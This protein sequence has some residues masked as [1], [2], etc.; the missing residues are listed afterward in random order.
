MVTA[1]G[2]GG[3][4]PNGAK[5]TYRSGW[6]VDDPFQGSWSTGERGFRA[7]GHCRT[8]LPSPHD[9]NAS[10]LFEGNAE[11]GRRVAQGVSHEL[12]RIGRRDSGIPNGA[13]VF[14]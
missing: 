7:G 10:G 14:A 11:L 1:V 8:G 6:H 4:Q 9:E 5:G 13:G 12:K 2:A 3:V